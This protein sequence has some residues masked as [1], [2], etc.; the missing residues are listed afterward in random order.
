[1]TTFWTWKSPC[2][3]G[4]TWIKLEDLFDL[5]Y[6]SETAA[7]NWPSKGLYELKGP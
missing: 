1:M 7:D 2:G 4:G 3:Q 5:T 6:T